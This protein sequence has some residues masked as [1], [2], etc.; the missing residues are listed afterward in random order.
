[1]PIYRYKVY[2]ENYEMTAG[3]VEAKNTGDV[4]NRLTKFYVVDIEEQKEKNSLFSFLYRVTQK[5]IA[6]F[7][8]SLSNLLKAG[9][10]I[11][12]AIN[13]I[14]SETLNR[15][16][17]VILNKIKSDLEKGLP[18]SYSLGKFPLSFSELYITTVKI[19][20]ETG[21]IAEVLKGL[22][23]HIQQEIDLK[24]KIKTALTYPV[25]LVSVL[26]FVSVFLIY[27]VFPR[28]AIFYKHLGAKLPVITRFFI[29]L[30]D[31]FK[32]NS[33][34]FLGLLLFFLFLFLF[35][36]KTYTGRRLFDR[37]RM[38][39]F[40]FGPLYKKINISLF[41]ESLEMLVQ[42]GIDI[43]SS[44]KIATG[45]VYSPIV[46]DSIER[47][48]ISLRN[49]DSLSNSLRKTGVFPSMITGIIGI[50]E[51]TGN[52]DEQ[53]RNILDIYNE[54]IDNT[55]KNLTTILEPIMLVIV[56]GFVLIVALALYLPIFNLLQ[57]IK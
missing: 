33:I 6:R 56:A 31:F 28:Y 40:I 10:P 24:R 32:I 2:N 8:S 22:F 55:L 44:L 3:L 17:R 21:K 47:A 48:D 49:G 15:K 43:L 13:I 12:S 38:K 16:M 11:L 30:P 35:F 4:F 57:I 18:L 29:F 5:D 50:G 34:N 41:C 46:K 54:E 26:V 14:T 23:N 19:G 42:S 53:L 36:S 20:E 7:S 37:F 45:P 39:L 51:E 27:F 52:L 25:L 1:M 9:I